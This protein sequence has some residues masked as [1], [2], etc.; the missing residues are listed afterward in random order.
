MHAAWKGSLKV[1]DFVVNATLMMKNI[2]IE[3]IFSI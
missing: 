1:D 3:Q 2:F